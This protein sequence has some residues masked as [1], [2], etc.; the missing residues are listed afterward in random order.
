M[1]KNIFSDNCV[2]TAITAEKT[3]FKRNTV[4]VWPDYGYFKQQ[5]CNFSIEKENF[6]ENSI[7][8]FTQDYQ[9][10]KDNKKI[11]YANKF[12]IG[13][14]N[15]CL[16]PPEDLHSYECRDREVKMYRPKYDTMMGAFL[17]LYETVGYIMVRGDPQEH[18]L[19]YG[20]CQKK[21]KILHF[22]Y[23]KHTPN[24]FS[25]TFFNCHIVQYE[26]GAFQGLTFFK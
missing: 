14:V 25:G 7:F 1:E 20:F 5:P 22:H 11:Y 18:F 10:V 23:K 6:P 2:E 8:Y 24:S 26:S 15:E 13:Q 3:S 19:D 17:G 21:S 16:N 9:L 4:D 12:L